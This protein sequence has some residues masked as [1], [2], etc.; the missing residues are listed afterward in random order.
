[1]SMNYDSVT[2]K[3]YTNLIVILSKTNKNDNNDKIFYHYL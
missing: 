3:R 1:M 2:I